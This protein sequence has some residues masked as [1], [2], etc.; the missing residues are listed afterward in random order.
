MFLT[1]R[2]WFHRTS[3]MSDSVEITLTE[4]QNAFLQLTC[5]YPLFVGGPGCGKS[6]LLGLAAVSDA[7][8]SKDADVYIY[9]PENHHIRTIEVP[10]VLYWLDVMKIKNKGYNKQENCVITEDPRC[11]NFYFKN[12]E[13]AATMV[14]YESYAAHVDELDTLDEKKAA[15]IWRAILMRNRQQPSGVPKT[16][17]RWDEEKQAFYAINRTRAYTTPEGYKFCYKTWELEGH[18]DYQQ[19]KGRTADN[20]A[21]PSKYVQSIKDRYPDHIAEAYLNGEFV[22]ME[23]LAVYYNYDPDL[24][25][26]FEEVTGNE[27]L[28]IGC[29]FNVD[30]TSATVYVRRAGGKE[31]HAVDEFVGVRDAATLA[32][33]IANR[34]KGHRIT[35]YPD[36]SGRARSNASSANYS[37]IQ[38]LERKGFIIRANK[39]NFIV[40]DRINATN[41][42]LAEGKLY[43]NKSKCPTVS[44]CLINQPFDK[45]GKPCKKTGYDHQNDAT[46]YPIVFEMGPAKSLFKVNLKWVV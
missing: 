15:E 22:N 2:N 7:L 16:N 10:N 46:T 20:P 11:G 29:D 26:S 37:S 38:E 19:V 45:H 13:T 40:E 28:Y 3:Q 44:R 8:H 32:H 21:L 39:K 25:H 41:K 12:M 9:A 14:G 35:M 5:D 36:S 33:E 17:M 27:P 18:P 31:W 42:A 4:S 43:V 34:Y 24:H 1:S 23:S 30:N 6:Y